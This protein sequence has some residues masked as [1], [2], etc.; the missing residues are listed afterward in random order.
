MWIT[1][2]S[3]IL[4]TEVFRGSERSREVSRESHLMRRD[5][6]EKGYQNGQREIP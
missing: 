6:I 2:G 3:E 4:R 1:G 5:W